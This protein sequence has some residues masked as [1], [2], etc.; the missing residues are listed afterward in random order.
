M[1]SFEERYEAMRRETFE[2]EKVQQFLLE[3]NQVI[4]KEMV[5]LSLPK[6]YEFITQATG[7]CG[8]G[9]YEKLYK[10]ITRV[11]AKAYLLHVTSLILR[12]NHVSK[13]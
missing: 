9:Q 13:S 2:H 3:N 5:E 10:F 11:C 1:P 12:M 6:L 8:C 7:C 4:T